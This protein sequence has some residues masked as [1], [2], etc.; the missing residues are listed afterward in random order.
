[1]SMQTPAPS[2]LIIPSTRTIINLV[3]GGAIGL[4]VWECWA[5][6][7][8]PLIV[9]YPL[10]PAGLL[11][12]LAQHLAGLNLPRLFRE[13]V[14]YGIGL[15]GYP[16]IYFAISRHVPRWP[17]ILDA[18]VIVTF[19]FSIFRDITAG[20][21]TPAKF[22]FLTA[23]IALVFSRLLNRD[24]RIANCISWGN[25]TWFFALGLMAPIAGLSFYLLGEGGELSYMSL[26][27]HVIYGYLAALVF[28]K[29]EDRQ[30]SSI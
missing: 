20:M 19:S 23:V 16:I 3:I 2:S 26:V 14:H 17:V 18:I 25:F 12:A 11:D 4:F 8:T 22:M 10:E 13:A 30:K 5:R 6:L 28:E 29:L 24:E 27:G 1:M 9:G 15:V 21:F 7:F